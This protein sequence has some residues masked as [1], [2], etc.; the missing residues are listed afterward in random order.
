MKRFRI[1]VVLI[2][3]LAPG[4]Q[5]PASQN[6]NVP[7]FAMAESS[8]TPTGTLNSIPV[9]TNTSF[10]P[11]EPPIPMATSDLSPAWWKDFG[12]SPTNIVAL[13]PSHLPNPLPTGLSIDIYPMRQHPIAE[14][15][16]FPQLIRALEGQSR[17]S[18]FPQGKHFWQ[19]GKL[20]QITEYNALLAPFGYRFTFDTSLDSADAISLYR[21]DKQILSGIDDM[22]HLSF[23]QSKTDFFLLLDVPSRRNAYIVLRANTIEDWN[24]LN[25][26]INDSQPQY[27]GDE[28]MHTENAVNDQP[29][30]ANQQTPQSIAH[31]LIN[32]YRGD[33]MIEQVRTADRVAATG[34]IGFWTYSNHWVLEVIDNIIVDGQPVNERNGYDRSYEF[35]LLNNRP[36]FFYEKAGKLGLN[37][38]DVEVPLPWQS[39]LHYGCCSAGSTNPEQIG[40]VLLFQAQSGEQWDYVELAVGPAAVMQPSLSF[41]PTPPAVRGKITANAGETLVNIRSGPGAIYDRI[42]TLFDGQTVMITGRSPNWDWF[43]IRTDN[44]EAWVYSAYLTVS[45]AAGIPC[46]EQQ[47]GDCAAAG[48]PAENDQVIA[49]IRA[50]RNDNN[51]SLTYKGDDSNPNA[52]LRKAF[53]YQDD[54]GSEYW[55]DQASLFV[56]QWTPKLVEPSGA[57]LSIDGLRTQARNFAFQQSP[58]LAQSASSLTFTETTKDGT[59]LAFR[60]EDRSAA[61]HT[62]YPFLQIILRTDGQMVGYM[63]TL[64]VLSK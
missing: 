14:D 52:D 27:L 35:H 12:E 33:Q 1:L 6:P 64:D 47:A 8:F 42:G 4:C 28:R 5:V 30:P 59:P 19:T 55:V 22:G 3:L 40:N 16:T 53:I 9:V 18:G 62:L 32:V 21:Q 13:D 20:A 46:V 61:G 57:I 25:G 26:W 60:W 41:T 49:R 23:N 29:T 10:T 39:I 34:Y 45:S 54:Q 37:F 15:L 51:L 7:T 2:L 44:T 38:D 50:F 63:N 43:R 58:R 17:F 31:H 24:H 48:L 36:V 56:V 11:T